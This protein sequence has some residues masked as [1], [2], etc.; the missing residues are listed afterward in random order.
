MYKTN[1]EI[2]LALTRFNQTLDRANVQIDIQVVQQILHSIIHEKVAKQLEQTTTDWDLNSLIR[3]QMMIR[4]DSQPQAPAV[5]KVKQTR[6]KRVV[7]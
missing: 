6:T 7:Q 1:D 5:E 3:L 4:D 2:R